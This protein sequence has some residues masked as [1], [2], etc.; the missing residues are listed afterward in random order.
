MKRSA[1]L[2]LAHKHKKRSAKW[3]FTKYGNELN[4]T[5]PKNG[6]VINLLIPKSN[7]Q[8][9]FGSG[10][11]NYMLVTPKGSPLPITLS[12]I[13]SASELDCAIPNCTKKAA[14]WHHIK[15]RKRIKGSSIQRAIYAY[16]AKQIPLCVNHHNLVHTGKYDGPSLRKLPG[17][18]PSDFN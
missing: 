8:I 2:T 14:H 13:C 17:Y 5:N 18:T 9:K 11:L 15:H 7:G 6:K 4:V 1:A 16:T 12:A 10:E 3:S